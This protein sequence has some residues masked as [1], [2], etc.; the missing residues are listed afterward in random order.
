MTNQK[1]STTIEKKLADLEDFVKKQP[2][3]VALSNIPPKDYDVELISKF[4]DAVFHAGLDSDENILTW[5]VKPAGQPG[6]P[7]SESQL[8]DQL[9]KTR[10]AQALYFNTATCKREDNKL[11]ARKALFCSLRVVVLDDIGTKV[12]LDRIPEDFPPSYI[13]ESS[14]ANFQY[15]YI[16]TD[17]VD[18]L[19]AA[20]ALIQLIYEAG[21]SDEGGKTPVKIVRLPDG[22]NGKKGEE[23]QF[24]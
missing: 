4:L 23:G 24:R 1:E 11:R 18:S 7:K 21:Y 3:A 12:P 14:K 9:E 2:A 13:I 8:F 10:N 15:G 22:V 19:V 17:P 5:A 16:L 20:D 6:Y